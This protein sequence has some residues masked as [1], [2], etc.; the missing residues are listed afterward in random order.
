MCCLG[1]WFCRILLKAVEFGLI[2]ILSV[3]QRIK[4][5]SIPSMVSI[6]I[7]ALHSV[8]SGIY[9]TQYAMQWNWERKLL[10]RISK[11]NYCCKH[12]FLAYYV[13]NSVKLNLYAELSGSRWPL[14][15][16]CGGQDIPMGFMWSLLA[17]DKC[18]N[19]HFVHCKFNL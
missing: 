14:F 6:V 8:L 18:K 5:I 9:I 11:E 10:F 3:I 4:R 12:A 16:V 19:F 13:N 2:N 15:W 1:L 7:P 17:I